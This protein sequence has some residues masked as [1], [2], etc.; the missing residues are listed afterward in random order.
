MSRLGRVLLLI[1]LL[2][3][4]VPVFSF[5]YTQESV[6]VKIRVTIETKTFEFEIG[7]HPDATEGF[8][9]NLDELTAPPP[10]IAP[11]AFLGIEE[12]PHF[13]KKDIRSYQDRTQWVLRVMDTKG[14]KVHVEWDIASS[15]ANDSTKKAVLVLNSEIDMMKTKE[16]AV[17][18][19]KDFIVTFFESEE[20]FENSFIDFGFY[21]KGEGSHGLQFWIRLARVGEVIFDIWD[22]NGRI[23]RRWR[24]GHSPSTVYLFNW[25]GKDD[26]GRA[27]PAG[28][29]V[30]KLEVGGYCMTRKIL[31]LH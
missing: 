4:I 12:F 8:D 7:F 14:Q 31:L 24:T 20:L 30:G 23:I 19:D 25:D 28:V 5:E 6:L 1:F 17:V 15:F 9:R 22:C 26:G 13:L 11:Y 10:R 16:I 2:S 29:Y 27:L 18:G 21:D 3:R